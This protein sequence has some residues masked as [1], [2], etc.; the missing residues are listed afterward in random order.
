MYAQKDSS[1]NESETYTD[2]ST[3]REV[4]R[5]SSQGP[6]H[7]TPT[8]HTN[9]DFLDDGEFLIFALV[10]EDKSAAFACQVPTGDITPLI[11]PAD[12]IDGYSTSCA[13]TWNTFQANRI[14][15]WSARGIGF[16]S[17]PARRS[18]Q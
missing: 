15:D 16:R 5:I 12:N 14:S 11:D 13:P 1:R 8:C 4:C 7:K 2:T 18:P 9:I 17:L 3:L 10:C 6:G